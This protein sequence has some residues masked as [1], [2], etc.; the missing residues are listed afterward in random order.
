MI[1]PEMIAALKRVLY[2]FETG[3]RSSMSDLFDRTVIAKT[4]E[5]LEKLAAAQG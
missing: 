3:V 2:G 5:K 4:I 1:D